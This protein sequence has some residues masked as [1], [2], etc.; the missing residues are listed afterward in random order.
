MDKYIERLIKQ[1]QDISDIV[2]GFKSEAVQIKIVEFLLPFVELKGK[3]LKNNVEQINSA[4]SPQVESSNQRVK[5]P[6]VKRVLDQVLLTDFFDTEK[7]IGEVLKFLNEADNDFKATEVSGILLALTKK[8][9]LK[10]YNS[11]VNNRFLYIRA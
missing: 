11:E 1:I 3:N 2:N 5:R 7:N 4:V 6:G 10:R 8:G 9:K